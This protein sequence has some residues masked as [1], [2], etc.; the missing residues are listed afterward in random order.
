MCNALEHGVSEFHLD[1]EPA[2]WRWRDLPSEVFTSTTLV[3]LSLG[4]RLRC[5]G[6]PSDTSLPA[7]RIL[8]LNSI[9][10]EEDQS[11]DV[12]LA[13]CPALED[14][15][16]HYKV[17]QGHSYVISSKTIKKLS[18]T[19]SF[20]FD[21]AFSRIISFDTPNV[22]HFYYSDYIWWESP[23]CRL[24]SFAKATLDLHFFND[25]KRYVKNGADMTDLI[26]RIR[27]VKNLHLTS[28]IVEV[29]TCGLP[30][31]N[32]LVD[33]VFSSKQ[34]GWKLLLPRLLHCSLYDIGLLDPPE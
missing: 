15:T 11:F 10:F 1:R 29:N 2:W 32:N 26:S 27:N 24:D 17:Y 33:L 18:V 22:I 34:K 21:F 9:W 19:F 12:F 7:L 13:A 16:I 3:K 31:F 28:S 5:Q 25:D 20:G 4:T 14:L 23:Q 8:F 6:I 30:V